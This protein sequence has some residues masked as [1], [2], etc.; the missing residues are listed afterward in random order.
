MYKHFVFILITCPF[1]NWMD[2]H[3]SWNIRKVAA[4]NL[5]IIIQIN[6]IPF[7]ITNQAEMHCRVREKRPGNN[8]A[9]TVSES[10]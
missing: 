9:C 7:Q 4:V 2:D 1:T 5:K 10:A 6:V 3:S 8:V